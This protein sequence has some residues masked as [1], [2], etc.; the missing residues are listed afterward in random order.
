MTKRH[1]GHRPRPTLADLYGQPRI[2][3]LELLLWTI[4]FVMACAPVLA[5][6]SLWLDQ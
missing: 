6:I 1:F 2:T 4:M 3:R 5:L